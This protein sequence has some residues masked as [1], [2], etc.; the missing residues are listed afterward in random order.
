MSGTIQCINCNTP[1]PLW[2]QGPEA[3]L[4]EPDAD[5][6][7]LPPYNLAGHVVPVRRQDQGEVLGD[8]N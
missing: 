5:P 8:S 1:S 4:F 7:F 6:F 3:V 2:F